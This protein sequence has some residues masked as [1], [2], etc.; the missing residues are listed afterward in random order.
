MERSA[1]DILLHS[2]SETLSRMA[3]RSKGVLGANTF[4]H[5]QSAGGLW[6]WPTKGLGLR[7][8]A[9]SLH[10]RRTEII[11]NW[12]N[13]GIIRMWSL[14]WKPLSLIVLLNQKK[15]KTLISLCCEAHSVV[16]ENSLWSY[17]RPL[18]I[19]LASSSDGLSAHSSGRSLVWPLT[20]SGPTTPRPCSPGHPH[21]HL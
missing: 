19:D 1:R 12:K 4:R 14:Y 3:A 18:R 6:L 9:M 15:R 5:C 2:G 11:G 8:A 7:P 20:Q 17:S 21:C 10:P 13:T 16:S